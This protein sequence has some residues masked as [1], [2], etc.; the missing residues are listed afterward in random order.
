M[1]INRTIQ[2]HL[3]TLKPDGLTDE[4]DKK[5]TLAVNRIASYPKYRESINFNKKDSLLFSFIWDETKEGQN[6]WSKLSKMRGER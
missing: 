4:E 6:F 5:W 3:Q 2:K 1:S